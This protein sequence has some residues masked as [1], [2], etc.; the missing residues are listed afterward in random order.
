[1]KLL[2][3]LFI[4]ALL[5]V[6]AGAQPRERKVP[7][8]AVPGTRISL[9]PPS[10]FVP[11]PQFAGFWQEEKG[12]SIMVMELPGP[13]SQVS[14]GFSD[15]AKLAARGI[16]VSSREEITIGGIKGAIF[17]M[18]QSA[19]GTDYVKWALLIGDETES[20]MVTATFP[21][22]LD[23]ELSEKLRQ[24]ILTSLWTRSKPIPPTEGVKFIVSESGDLRFARRMAGTLSFTRKGI[25]PSPSI[26][27]P[28][29]IVGQSY[30]KG[31]IRDYEAFAQSRILATVN[32]SDI[33]IEQT[34]PLE[35]DGLGGYEI[36]ATGKD[37]DSG[38]PLLLY[39]TIL[40]EDGGYYIMHG[41]TGADDRETYT[42]IFS[43][44]ARTFRRTEK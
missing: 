5:S 24:S 35:I 25:F 40:F 28:L 13:Y 23:A 17:R 11:S 7:A 18:E 42:T 21:R 44:M 6:E 33:T 1:M 38:E 34:T 22:E 15:S 43:E 4:L 20:V 31:M 10:G 37:R 27:D 30:S 36:L 32:V 41:R 8:T 19:Y 3:L 9:V 26:Y 16:A 39:Q 29:F 14:A 2:P 12:A